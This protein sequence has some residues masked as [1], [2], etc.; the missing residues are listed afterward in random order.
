MNL[1][2]HALRQLSKELILGQFAKFINPLIDRCSAMILHP[3]LVTK[4]ARL[5]IVKV[6]LLT[7]LK[8]GVITFLLELLCLQIITRIKLITDGQRHNIQ[9]LQVTSHGHHL[10]Y[11]LLRTVVRVLGTSLALRNPNI[12]ALLC[13]SKM[14]ITAHQLTALKHLVSRQPTTN[15]KGLVHTYQSLNPRINQQIVANTNLHCG[16]IAI[17][18]QQQIKKSGI[19]HDI[20]MIADKR[21]ALVKL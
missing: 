21:V 20:T 1:T 16:G 15:R 8:S 6:I 4:D 10:Q 17:L 3:A 12:L 18:K 19:K 2:V 11:R 13:D 5:H 14:D 9:L 7:L